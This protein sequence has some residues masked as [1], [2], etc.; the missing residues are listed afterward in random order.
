MTNKLQVRAALFVCCSLLAVS[1]SATAEAGWTRFCVDTK[2]QFDDANQGEDRL[3]HNVNQGGV[4]YGVAD[5]SYHWL[6]MNKWN[7]SQ[8]VF[9]D[10]V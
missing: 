8:W 6:Y 2:Y 1:V 5:S 10:A 3:L 9:H 4:Q 7:G